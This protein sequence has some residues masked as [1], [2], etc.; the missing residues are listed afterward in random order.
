MA[1]LCVGS[2]S[3]ALARLSVRGRH[4]RRGSVPGFAGFCALLYD[5]CVSREPPGE[6]MGGDPK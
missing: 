6:A 5:N 4:S 1:W 2:V 3:L